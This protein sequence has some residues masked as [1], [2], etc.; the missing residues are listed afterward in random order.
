MRTNVGRSQ[1]LDQT[2]GV[3]DPLGRQSFPKS[4][5]NIQYQSTPRIAPVVERMITCAIPR[6]GKDHHNMKAVHSTA[7]IT[8]DQIR[9]RELIFLLL[10]IPF[11]LS[12][13]TRCDN[14][15]TSPPRPSIG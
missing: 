13:V 11:G 9:F 14:V 7:N 4:Q 15:A 12:D 1:T 3:Q 5:P 8:A 2:Y 6:S 10:L